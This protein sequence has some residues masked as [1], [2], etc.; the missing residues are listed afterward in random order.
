MEKNC[1]S[2]DRGFLRENGKISC[3][4]PVD[5]YALKGGDGI[6][7]VWAERKY[8]PERIRKALMGDT[9]EP[10][11]SDCED[12]DPNDGSNCQMFEPSS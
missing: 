9:S 8:G 11:G 4:A 2:C 3:G 7:P 10:E 5:D 12:M 6:N 1:G